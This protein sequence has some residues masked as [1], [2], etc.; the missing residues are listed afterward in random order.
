MTAAPVERPRAPGGARR[1][2]APAAHPFAFALALWR[3]RSLA[4]RLA[5]RRIEARYRGAALGLF[6]A[7]L[8][9]LAMLTIYTFV[10]SAV[11]GAR[12]GEEADSRSFALHLFSGLILFQLFQRAA[13]EAPSL[14]LS[15]S[16]YLK[17]LIFP[18]EALSIASV[19]AGLFDV[20]VGLALWLCFHA[21]ERGAPPPTAF[22]IPL[23]IVPIAL[24]ALGVSWAFASLGVFLRD[25]SH[26]TT[27]AVT[28]LLFLSPIFYPATRVP[29]AFR[30][31]Y[32]LNPF[33]HLLEAARAM[34]LDGTQPDWFAIGVVTLVAW[35]VAWAGHTWFMRTRHTFADVL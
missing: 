27:L 16:T 24:F 35:A 17:Q 20:V 19:L 8:E 29:E 4:L 10:F 22:A 28:A 7:V 32:E 3:H 18:A 1:G 6:W 25:L 12:W 31:L 14:L 34:L 26:V 2:E 21:I 9:P 5:R 33:A 13:N 11:L 23:V 15:H 30:G